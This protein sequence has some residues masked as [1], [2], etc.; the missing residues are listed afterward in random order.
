MKKLRYE[1]TR[2]L[3]F[4]STVTNHHFAICAIPNNT[5]Q[6]GLIESDFSIT[7][8]IKY[9]INKDTFG[10][11]IISG[12]IIDEHLEFSF[13]SSG[14]IKVS[15]APYKDN[16]LLAIYKYSTPLTTVK[17]KLLN[18]YNSLDIDTSRNKLELAIDLMYELGKSFEYV[19]NTTN[20]K[21][22]SWEAFE[23]GT[24]VCQDFAHILIAM[25]RRAGVPARYV[26]GFIVGEGATHAWIEVN[27]NGKWYGL[28]PTHQKQ[29]DDNYIRLAT[30]RDYNDANIDK[31]TF[32]GFTNQHQEVIVKVEDTRRK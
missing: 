16:K 20:T 3:T 13:R 11:S 28:D 19:S 18:F 17:G 31:G 6:Q 5:A 4:D 14:I 7:P 30:G 21:T 9:E 25:C 32:C 24:G 29:V 27:S 10:N 12:E 15:N 1:F 26:V 2:K 8:D 22:T 23:Q